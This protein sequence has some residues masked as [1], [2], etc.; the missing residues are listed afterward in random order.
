MRRKVDFRSSA[1]LRVYVPMSSSDNE[2]VC[3]Q[4][5]WLYRLCRRVFEDGIPFQLRQSVGD[6]KDS[7][8]IEISLT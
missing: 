8:K 1:L 7:Q 5:Q 4:L 2:E 3:T 6:S